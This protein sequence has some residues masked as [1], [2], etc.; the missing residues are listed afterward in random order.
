MIREY[1]YANE[2]FNIL[3]N[4]IMNIDIMNKSSINIMVSVNFYKYI[5]EYKFMYLD[6]FKMWN[7]IIECDNK[8]G[9]Y[10][11]NIDDSLFVVRDVDELFG[12]E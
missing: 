6:F 5:L 10:S 8:L 9:V 4:D 1:T 12:N 2:C 7:V 3:Y 11:Y